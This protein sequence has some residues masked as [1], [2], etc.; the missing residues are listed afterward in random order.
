MAIENIFDYDAAGKRGAIDKRQLDV[1]AKCNT[2]GVSGQGWFRNSA[3]K[4]PWDATVGCR[5]WQLFQWEASFKDVPFAVD[6]DVRTGGRRVQVHEYPSRE[7][8]DN[9]DLGRLRQQV[10]VEGYVFGDSSDL[11][12]EQLF[13]ACTDPLSEK[14]TSGAGILYL[15]LRVPLWAVCMSVE[16]TWTADRMGRIDFSM[17]FSIDPNEGRV[18]VKGLGKKFVTQLGDAVNRAARQAIG[19]SLSYFDQMFTGFQPS[20]ARKS[21]AEA[22]R[23]TGLLLRVAAKAVRLNE[24][25]SGVVDFI[26][27]RFIEAADA[28]ADVQRTALNTMNR[29][30]AVLSQR[31]SSLSYYQLA[32]AGLAV[33]ASTG[34]VLPALGKIGEGFG[35][36]LWNALEALQIGSPRDGSNASDLAQ[37]LLPLTNLKP[38]VTALSAIQLTTASVQAELQ[39]AE[40]V[41][42]VVRR[43]ALCYSIIAGINVAPPKQPDASLTRTRLLQQ[44]DEEVAKVPAAAPLQASLRTLRGAVIDF[45]NW[46]SSHGGSSVQIPESWAGKPLAAIAASV[47]GPNAPG[48]DIDLM[49]FNGV[50]HPMFA[51]STMVALKDGALLVSVGL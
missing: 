2:T 3:K 31:A 5:D 30:A 12:A 50:T 13:A 33:R 41:C 42:A 37:A 40:T 49:R 36:M 16:S 26:A 45:V 24:T 46:Y 39:L 27:G 1:A 14:S 20:V 51:P 19:D 21:A 4:G 17:T 28:Y 43:L 9:E 48:R 7:T 25:A 18:P 34:E 11:W 47:Y 15:P 32:S 8:W 44:I 29:Q 22:I 6:S 23:Q 10:N 35:G 38:A